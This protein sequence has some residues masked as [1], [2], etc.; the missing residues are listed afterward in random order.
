MAEVAL[1]RIQPAQRGRYIGELHQSSINPNDVE[2]TR[3]G[4]LRDAGGARPTRNRV[5]SRR[6]YHRGGFG[7]MVGMK[8]AVGCAHAMLTASGKRPR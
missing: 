2:G 8:G 1:S 4:N 7:G 3:R 6:G 5:A